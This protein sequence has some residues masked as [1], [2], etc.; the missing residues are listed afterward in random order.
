ME[1]NRNRREKEKQK[2]SY[3]IAKNNLV[4]YNSFVRGKGDQNFAGF[5]SVLS[6]YIIIYCI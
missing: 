2:K 1:I 5:F 3:S 6:L 4:N